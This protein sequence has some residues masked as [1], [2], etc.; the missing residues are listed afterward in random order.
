MKKR[1]VRIKIISNELEKAP[2]QQDSEILDFLES[3]ARTNPVLQVNR[4][5]LAKDLRTAKIQ[6]GNLD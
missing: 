4:T 6:R 1:I 2:N 5:T 3:L